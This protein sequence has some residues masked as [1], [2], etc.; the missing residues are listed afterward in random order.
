[1]LTFLFNVKKKAP[2]GVRRGWDLG[3]WFKAD[4]LVN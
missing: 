1:M 4:E 3:S 2:P